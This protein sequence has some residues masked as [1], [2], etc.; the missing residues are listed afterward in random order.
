MRIVCTVAI[1]NRV[2]PTLSVKSQNKHVKSTLALCK[3]PKKDHE[4]MIIHFTAQNK[5]G[6]KYKLLNNINGVLTKFINEGKATIQ[7][8]EPPHDLYIQAEHIQLRGFLLLLKRALEGKVTPKE[9]TLSSMS[10]TA[11]PLKNIAPKKLVVKNRSELPTK[12]F[13]RTL[14][15][16]HINEIG[17]S[18]LCIG[19]LQLQKLRVLDIS[20]NCIEYLPNELKNL[21]LGELNLSKNQ[22]GKSTFNQWGWIGGI[23]LKSLRTINI[24][25][26]NLRYLPGQ[27]V[28]F[29]G[30]INISLDNNQLRALPAGFGN[31]RNLR[32]LSVS[33]NSLVQVP[34]SMKR[35]HLENLDISNNNFRPISVAAVFP[36]PLP[37][38]TLKE[39]A[40]R[41]VLHA[42]LPYSSE[43]VP[44]IL[45]EYLDNAHYCVCGRACFE[46]HLHHA[47]A[48]MWKTITQSCVSTFGDLNYIPMDGYYCSLRCFRRTTFNSMSH[49]M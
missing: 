10:V 29:E 45:V 27:F 21:P 19:I 23:L 13:P 12:G 28:K 7:F 25:D 44:L 16:V 8:K 11:V 48:L 41:K 24:S 31:F 22:L 35:L 43:D 18:K 6:T 15:S 40:A 17:L 4:Y 26:N 14:E 5:T 33:N 30:I 46:V 1:G 49:D 2:L 20:D 3:H 38:C 42:K 9:L 36:K 39:S 32:T 37:V 47:Y 34:G